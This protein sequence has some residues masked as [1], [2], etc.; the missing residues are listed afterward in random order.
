M[1]TVVFTA[2]PISAQFRCDLPVRSGSSR[3]QPAETG[4]FQIFLEI[5]PRYVR[6]NFI[7]RT[8][9]VAN[10]IVGQYFGV[11]GLQLFKVRTLSRATCEDLILCSGF[12]KIQKIISVTLAQVRKQKNTCEIQLTMRCTMASLTNSLKIFSPT[13][14]K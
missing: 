9:S 4:Y 5:S 2:Y 7:W 12:S 13:F 1:K 11:P 14:P 6:V 10:I 8:A 3:L